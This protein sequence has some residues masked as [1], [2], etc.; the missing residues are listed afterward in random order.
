MC[1]VTQSCPT[2][3][4]C[5][6]VHGESPG[7]NTGVGCHALLQ[8]NLPNPWRGP[9]SPAL[10]A[11]SLPSEP[12]RKPQQGS[13]S[14]QI[15]V[16]IKALSSKGEKG[17]LSLSF[18]ILN[19]SAGFQD[20]E[21]LFL[22]SNRAGASQ[23]WNVPLLDGSTPPASQRLISAFRRAVLANTWFIVTLG[24]QLLSQAATGLT[25]ILMLDA[26]RRAGLR[27]GK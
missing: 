20:S 6:S 26:H 22:E 1:L 4:D 13:G 18:F 9:R 23:F 5:S 2:L 25:L 27:S 16:P 8:G 17:I 15:H 3:S 12:P 10:Q 14:D 24:G 19:G 21:F 11:D 7:R